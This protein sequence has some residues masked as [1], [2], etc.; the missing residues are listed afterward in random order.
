[1]RLD[2]HRTSIDAAARALM[3]QRPVP[4]PVGPSHTTVAPA[5]EAAAEALAEDDEP[6]PLQPNRGCMCVAVEELGLGVDEDCR[7]S[8]TAAATNRGGCSPPWFDM[9]TSPQ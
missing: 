4:H 3:Q 1:M 5:A 8:A 9:R 6:R 7:E 2:E